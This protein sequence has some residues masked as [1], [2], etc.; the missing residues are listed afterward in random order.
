[1]VKWWNTC[2]QSLVLIWLGTEYLPQEITKHQHIYQDKW[3]SNYIHYKVCDEII[4]PFT[5][6]NGATI[7]VWEWIS[8]HTLYNGCNYISMLQLKLNH[9]SKRSPYC[10]CGCIWITN[11]VTAVLCQNKNCSNLGTHAHYPIR[12]GQS[13]FWLVL[14]CCHVFSC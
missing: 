5:N 9:F 13:S 11:I 3:I 12:Y 2:G 6:F 10:M 4:Y 7:E 1:M 14:L 8:N